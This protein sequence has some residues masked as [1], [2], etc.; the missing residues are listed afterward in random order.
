M[1]VAA[2]QSDI[3]WEDPT[4]N[5]ERLRPWLATAAAAGARLV[6]LPEMF[7]CGFS[8]KTE[9]VRE[10]ADGPSVRFLEGQA[11]AHGLWL[12][13]SIP[14]LPL[15]AARPYNTLVLAGPRGQVH[16]YRKIHPFTFARENE[17]YQAGTEHVTVD[18]E[19]LRCTLFVCYDLR[20]AD[21]FWGRA[22]A[23]DA[24]IVV[25]NWPDRR[26]HHW[27]TLLRARAIENQAYVV[28]VNRVGRGNGLDYVGDSCI[29][30]PWGETLAAAAGSETLLLA[31][32]DP[33]VVRDA[34]EKFPILADRRPDL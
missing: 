27:T 10:P 24:Y 15:G 29:I 8:M 2:I 9:R 34:R 22:H 4:A 19:G 7:A 28:G 13:G 26:R 21:E 6:A 11:L 17:H 5:F 30:D 25:A 20:F 23:T 1:R 14:E 16:R 32:L 12:C 18:V 33:A 31:D 3:V